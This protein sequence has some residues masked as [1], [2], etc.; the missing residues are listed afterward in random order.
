MGDLGGRNPVHVA[1]LAQNREMELNFRRYEVRILD[2]GE[3][4]QTVPRKVFFFQNAGTRTTSIPGSANGL[5]PSK[6][7]LTFL[8]FTT[9]MAVA[10]LRSPDFFQAG[11]F[12]LSVGQKIVLRTNSTL[13]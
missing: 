7:H 8:G 11:I 13:T 4:W 3:E 9:S 1:K 5:G 6:K 2:P 10:G 12:L